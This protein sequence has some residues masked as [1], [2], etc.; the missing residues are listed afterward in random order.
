MSQRKVKLKH[1]F[2]SYTS[3]FKMFKSI[4]MSQ[5]WKNR[6]GHIKLN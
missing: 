2:F 3:V 1:E 4:K 6:I 5:S